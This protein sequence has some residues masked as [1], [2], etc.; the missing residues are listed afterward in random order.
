MIKIISDNRKA[1]K[2]LNK[3]VGIIAKN[4]G[5]LDGDIEVRCAHGNVSVHSPGNKQVRQ[6]FR[7]PHGLLLPYEEFEIAI[8]KNKFVLVSASEDVT[9]VQKKLM[10]AMLEL[11]NVTGKLAQHRATSPWLMHK[12]NKALMEILLN[13][14]YGEEFEKMRRMIDEGSDEELELLTFF[15][16]RLLRCRLHKQWGKQVLVILPLIDALNHHV[17]GAGFDHIYAKN[18]AAMSVACKQL[19]DSDE[20][21]ACY[22]AMDAMDSYLHYGFV[23]EAAPFVRSAP[24]EIDL[25]EGG[26]IDVQASYGGVDAEELPEP[27]KDLVFFMPSITVNHKKK[28]AQLSHLFIP[29]KNGILSMRRILNYVI[30]ILNPDLED[31]V[32]IRWLAEAERM[33]LETN[34]KLYDD[35]EDVTIGIGEGEEKDEV[36][37][38]IS[39]QK[40]RIS[41]YI[42]SINSSHKGF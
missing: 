1:E 33:V 18:G 25:G 11:Y 9:P 14:R 12:D 5:Y 42:S 8:K 10:K 27:L 7:I 28:R 26:T 21:L 29:Q 15:K 38:F 23:D 20:C 34:I 31:Q 39:L 17:L 16:T 40:G 3:I 41:T 24:I 13:C 6:M 30:R 32:Y 36:L 4:G 19:P 22:G 37:K 35:I 2:I